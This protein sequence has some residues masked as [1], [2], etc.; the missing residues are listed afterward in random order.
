MLFIKAYLNYGCFLVFIDYCFTRLVLLNLMNFVF[1]L[2][3]GF[4]SFIIIIKITELQKCPKKIFYLMIVESVSQQ[5]L[6][7]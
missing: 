2:K 3:L 6:Y 4:S 7:I 5:I 1:S